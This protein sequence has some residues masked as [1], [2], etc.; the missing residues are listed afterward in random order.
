[1][2]NRSCLWPITNMSNLMLIDYSTG[3]KKV[4]CTRREM[5][6]HAYDR[7]VSELDAGL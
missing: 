5:G 3:R 1:M 6:A 2:I 7:A 4:Y